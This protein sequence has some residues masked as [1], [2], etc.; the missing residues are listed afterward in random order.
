MPTK[1][2]NEIAK[3]ER[4]EAEAAAKKAEPKPPAVEMSPDVRQHNRRVVWAG[5]QAKPAL[6]EL[7]RTDP[8]FNRFLK[9]A[10]TYFTISGVDA[11]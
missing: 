9:D 7:A 4:Q 8:V 10:C 11:D 3:I 5:L 1:L 2:Q 6:V